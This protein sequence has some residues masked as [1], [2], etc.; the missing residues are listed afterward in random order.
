MS[1][2]APDANK[3]LSVLEDIRTEG[4]EIPLAEALRLAEVTA[5]TARG[6]IEE[7][8][9]AVREEFHAIAAKIRRLKDEVAGFSAG[10]LLGEDLPRASEE[11]AA[12]V[13]ETEDSAGRILGAAEEIMAA[14]PSDGAAYQGAVTD[15]AMR[16]LEACAF[17]DLTGQRISKVART[18]SDIEGRFVHLAELVGIDL[19]AEDAAP[20]SDEPPLAGPALEGEGNKQDDVD[21]LFAEAGADGV[22][23][24]SA[25]DDLF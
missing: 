24:Q 20:Q 10:R 11:L 19:T 17:Q 2:T 6:L 3:I 8:D 21:R 9:Q 22:L 1:A 16:I 4:S 18:L 7:T 14:D 12:I 23:D 5:G 25:I 13:S 15:A